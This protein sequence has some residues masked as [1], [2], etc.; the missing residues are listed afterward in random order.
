MAAFEAAPGVD[1]IVVVAGPSLASR[2]GS[3]LAGGYRK[4]SRVLPGGETGARTSRAAISALDAT[5]GCVLVHDAA[6]P[7]VSPRVIAECVAALATWQAVCAVVPASDTMVVV[8][9]GVK[10]GRAHV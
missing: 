2:A 9:E 6:R 1:E 5:G 7:L 8:R 10:I 4:L 3:L